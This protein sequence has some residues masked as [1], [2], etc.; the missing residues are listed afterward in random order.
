VELVDA[1]LTDPVIFVELLTLI[2]ETV[3]SP[4]SVVMETVVAGQV[5]VAFDLVMKFVPVNVTLL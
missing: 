3:T 1:T 4:S 2:P 5:A